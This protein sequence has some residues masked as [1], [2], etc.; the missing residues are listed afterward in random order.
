[1]SCRVADSE[2]KYPTFPK[3]PTPKP[4]SLTLRDRN[5]AVKINGNRDAQQEI[6]VSTKDSKEFVSCQQE[7]PV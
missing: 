7:F 4:D 3:F 6:S 2:V 1:M 5:L